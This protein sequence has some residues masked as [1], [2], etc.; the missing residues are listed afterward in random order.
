LAGVPRS[1]STPGAAI[2]TVSRSS[3]PATALPARRSRTIHSRRS[4]TRTNVSERELGAAQTLGSM[5][6]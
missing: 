4:I 3:C 1:R 5:G 6:S 2:T